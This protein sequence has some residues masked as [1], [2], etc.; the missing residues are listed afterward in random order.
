M[1][2]VGEFVASL[3][4]VNHRYG[5]AVALDGVTLDVPSNRMV[6]IIGPDGVGKST[7]LALIAGVRK[8]QAG[9]VVVLGGDIGDARF[10][11]LASFRV[12]YLPQGLGKNLYPTLSIFEN[13]DFFGRLFGQ[14]RE[15][16][17]WRIRDLFDSTDLT[18]FRDR[19]AGKLS[20]GMKQKLGLC[21]SLIHDPDLLILDEPTTGVDPLARRQFWELID[22]IRVRRPTMSVMVA[23]AYMD[24]AE[25]F[26]WLVAMNAGEVLATGTPDELKSSTNQ[27][28][29]EKAFIQLLPE[30]TRR[31][32]KE[33]EIAPW[34]ST[35]GTPAIEAEGLTQ[36][37]GAFTAVDHVSFRIERGEIFGFLGSNGCGKTTTMKMLTGLL[38]PT[39]GTALLFGKPV[40]G[41]DVESRRHVGFMSQAFS[42]YTELTVRQNLELHARL[43]DLPKET[44]PQRIEELLDVFGLRTT[45]DVL[46][47]SLPMGIRQRLS[48]AVA[49]IHEPEMLILDEPT[50]GVD[51]VA[52]DG[53]WEL[54]IKLSRENGVTIFL[55]THFMNE[56]AR[57]DRMS[58][59][60]AGKVLAQGPPAKLVEER[61]AASLE[62]AF[63]G[64]LEEAAQKPMVSAEA[65]TLA[66]P[67]AETHTEHA[68][69]TSGRFSLGRVW[70]FARRETV[71]LLRDPIRIAFALLGP[72]LLMI[73]FGYGISLDV[74]HLP[75]A[76][77]DF[78]NS[79]SSR[80]YV[81]A[82][83]GSYYFVE[84]TPLTSYDNLDYRLRDGDLRFALEIPSGFERDLLRGRK[85]EVVSYI[86]A[87]I[88]FR[89][90][91]T[92]NYVQKVNL[93]YSTDLRQKRGL[94][95]S[96]AGQPV[97]F[98]VRLLYNQAFKSVY[99]MVPADI[100][101]LLILIPCMLT[102]LAV[103]R[104]KELGSIANFYSAPATRFEF[105]IGKQMPYLAVSF[106]QFASLV[107]IALFVFQVPM[108][109]SWLTLISGGALYLVAS[110]GFGLLI[111][112]FAPT[113]TAAIF[114][115][116][117]ITILPAIQFSGMYAPVSSLTGGARLL[118]RLFPSTYFQAISVGTF[119]KAL[120]FAA[121]WRNFVAITITALLYFSVSVS[122]LQKQ[123]R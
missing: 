19:P 68:P 20:G 119:T 82:F 12:A 100:M 6:G 33:P 111:S 26:D 79:P 22:R 112:V 28:T 37:F 71:E 60:H 91:L 66:A 11:R 92:R 57:C 104:E 62:D 21:C 72:V 116:A 121:L 42:L 58:M 107:L 49:V 122:L 63:I 17:E 36:R 29:L 39:D 59:M 118:S 98:N 52:R 25:R 34:Q 47:E 45:A 102:A 32:H 7:M 65:A 86:D 99:A 16:R 50:S 93:Q 41:G 8:I 85:P 2:E 101:L 90:E 46:A 97:A 18:P 108:K 13:I 27:P 105:L 109:G 95:T 3:R 76:V 89:A 74:D 120:G 30:E 4:D 1:S 69:D 77:L 123:E 40:K 64:Y 5:T 15:E 81:D 70:A 56:A 24:E 75:F 88:P 55:S 83:R 38:P 51:P 73:V 78:D 48:L 43:F 67:E 113:Q 94:P 110:V 106:I 61:K 115:A 10:R 96:V 84:Q 114:A 9:K 31:G 44:S 35:G 23:T 53:F 87:A 117:I 14:S 54:L 103:V 80:A